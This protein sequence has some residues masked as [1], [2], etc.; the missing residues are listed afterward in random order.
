M[1]QLTS[2]RQVWCESPAISGTATAGWS[3]VA[4]RRR[5][6]TWARR[7]SAR[8][9]RASGGDTIAGSTPNSSPIHRP[10]QYM[11]KSNREVQSHARLSCAGPDGRRPLFQSGKRIRW[12]SVERRG[13]EA[14]Q[15]PG[16][17]R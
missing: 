4:G 12:R 2:G 14:G 16:G 11:W 5:R 13:R 9:W 3:V 1:L 7:C 8:G 15:E 6:R 17:E 10:R